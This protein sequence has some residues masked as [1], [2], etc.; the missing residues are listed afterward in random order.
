MLRSSPQARTTLLAISHRGRLSSVRIDAALVVNDPGKYAPVC[1]HCDAMTPRTV[2]RALVAALAVMS[3]AA[4]SEFSILHA[5]PAE[6]YLRF[7]L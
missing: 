5:H 7:A 3:I 6:I 4:I 2:A 1:S